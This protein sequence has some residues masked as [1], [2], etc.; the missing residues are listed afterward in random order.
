MASVK[1]PDFYQSY[2]LL[3]AYLAYLDETLN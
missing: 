2:R 1:L 3:A